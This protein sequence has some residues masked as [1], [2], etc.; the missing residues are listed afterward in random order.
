VGRGPVLDVQVSIEY[1]ASLAPANGG[2]T[3]DQ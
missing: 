1:L 2:G 3:Q